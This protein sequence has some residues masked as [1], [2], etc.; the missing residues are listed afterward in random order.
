MWVFLKV[1]FVVIIAPLEMIRR[2]ALMCGCCEDLR[3]G[4]WSKPQCPR[5]SRRLREAM[6]YIRNAIASMKRAATNLTFE[7]CERVQWVYLGVIL[8]ARKTALEMEAKFV[9]LFS[10]P[11]RVACADEPSEALF[12][13]RI[14]RDTPDEKLCTLSLE[15]KDT[16]PDSLQAW[17][18]VDS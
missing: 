9:W 18:P 14:L 12:C 8:A 6:Y 10:V 11:W 3:T 2:W 5:A 15:Y 16:F 1:M 7:L 17:T 4:N 13:F